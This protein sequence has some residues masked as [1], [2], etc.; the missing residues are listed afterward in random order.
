[1]TNGSQS[2]RNVCFVGHPSSGKSTLVDTLANLA[3]A[4]PRKGSTVGHSAKN[5]LTTMP[6][7]QR[8]SATK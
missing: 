5:A 8:G 3:G 7:T 6:K 1:M 4:S 2:I